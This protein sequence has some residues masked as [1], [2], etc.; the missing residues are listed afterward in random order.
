MVFDDFEG[1]EE[2]TKIVKSVKFSDSLERNILSI[3]NP[4]NRLSFHSIYEYILL[5]KGRQRK[6]KDHKNRNW[7]DVSEFTSRKSAAY[8]QFNYKLDTDVKPTN[9]LEVHYTI[10]ENGLIHL[11]FRSSA[12]KDGLSKVDFIPFILYPKGHKKYNPWNGTYFNAKSLKELKRRIK[13]S[14]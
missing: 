4:E 13:E 3:S 2:K 12:T 9:V 10:K 7:I 14:K 11:K 5:I 6:F 8:V 1:I